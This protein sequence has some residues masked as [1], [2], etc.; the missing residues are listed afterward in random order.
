MKSKAKFDDSTELFD[1]ALSIRRNVFGEDHP[2][3]DE[4]LQKRSELPFLG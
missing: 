1:K 4:V 3:V 2:D